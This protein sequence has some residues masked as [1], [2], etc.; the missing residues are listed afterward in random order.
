MIFYT[1]SGNG[2]V[3][4]QPKNGLIQLQPVLPLKETRV[5]FQGSPCGICGKWYWDRFSTSPSVF[6]CQYHSTAAPYSLMCH[7]EDG[8]WDR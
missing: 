8:Q 1:Q 2:M 4:V 5:R 3:Q 6:P 7:L